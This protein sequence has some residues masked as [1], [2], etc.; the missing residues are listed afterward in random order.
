[1]AIPEA[2]VFVF[3]PS[4]L[5]RQSNAD[6]EIALT[7]SSASLDEFAGAMNAILARARQL[8][9]LVNVDS[10]LRLANPQL[11]IAFDRER[12]ADL[13]VPVSAVSQALAMLVSQGKADDFILRNEQYDVVMALESPF[14]TV[15]E[16]LAQ[17]HVRTRDGAMVPL[18]A[19]IEVKPRIGPTFLNHYDLQRSATLT[20]NLA[21]GAALGPALDAVEK[22]VDEELPA[23][24]GKQLRGTSREFRESS[25]AIYGTFALALLVIYLVLAAQFE[26]FLHPFTVLLS[27]PLATLGALLS[28]YVTGNSINLYSQIGIILLVGLVTKN[29][30]LL[31]DFAN[32]ERARGASLIDALRRAGHTRFRPIV[33]TSATSILGA[34]PLVIPMGPGAES[35]AAI[36]TAVVGGLLFSTV[37]TLVMIPVFH[38]FVVT[39]AERLGLKTI[40][41]KVEFE[42]DAGTPAASA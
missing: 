11:D 30:I 19:M 22:I 26:S 17:I 10:D 42:Q 20:A 9:M 32:Q 29:A 4:S 6:V 18:A 5:Q 2:L 1:M 31:V 34:V 14:R 23:G 25:N 40:P 3:S 16:Q 36:G 33:M 28:L 13:G 7:S 24:F 12:A 39:L 15:P 8:P 37:F 21:P 41:P 35:R 27:V 38:Y